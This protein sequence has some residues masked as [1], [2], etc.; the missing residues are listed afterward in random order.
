[1]LTF[2]PA[3]LRGIGIDLGRLADLD[4]RLAHLRRLTRLEYL[5]LDDTQ[6]T[7]AGLEHLTG[8]TQLQKLFLSGPQVTGTVAT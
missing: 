7:D 3:L 2:F 1:M 8:L 4:L 5:S 6:V